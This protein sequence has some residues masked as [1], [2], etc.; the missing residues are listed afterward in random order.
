MTSRS[1]RHGL[2]G[3][4]LSA[5]ILGSWGCRPGAERSPQG[6]PLELTLAVMRV[7][8]SGLIAIAAEK[9]YFREAGVEVK[10]L[11]YPSGRRALEAVTRGEAEMATVSSM[12]FAA[13]ALRDPSVRIL[14]SI[15]TTTGARIVARRDRG[16]R[17][18][19]DLIG[20][21][22][23]YSAGT[24]SEYLLFAFLL[25]EGIPLESVRTV[26]LPPG[27]QAE[28]VMSGEVDAVSAFEIHAFEAAKILG[29]IIVPLDRQTDVSFHWLLAVREPYLRSPEPAERLLKALK[30]A[31]DFLQ[32]NEEEA[33]KILESR[34]GFD[35]MLLET[36]FRR[37]RLEVSFKQAVVSSLINYFAWH[38]RRAGNP[39][40]PPDVLEYMHMGILEKVSPESVTVFR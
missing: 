31:E 36:S 38:M 2:L 24:E 14:A 27:R 13:E 40:N 28:A 20:K 21:R 23:G 3:L 39:G 32:K 37:N 11:S 8:Y 17:E 5:A 16:I 35:P 4:A 25:T 15:G 29:N 22:V 19:S 34:W 18:P 30:R 7:P 9:G 6:P 12:A 33:R 26:D 1:V 10:E